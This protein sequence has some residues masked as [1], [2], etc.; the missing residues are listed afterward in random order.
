MRD[1][2]VQLRRVM[3]SRWDWRQRYF[4]RRLFTRFPENIREL[5]FAFAFFVY[6]LP[7]LWKLF[8][9]IFALEFKLIPPE[10]HTLFPLF[11]LS[12]QKSNSPLWIGSV[13][14]IDPWI[15]RE[16]WLMT[17]EDI[18]NLC[19]DVSLCV[20]RKTL[21]PEG[22]N[23]LF[24]LSSWN[25]SWI[26]S[27]YEKNSE[28]AV[29]LT[30]GFDFSQSLS[31]LPLASFFLPV[32]IPPSHT[33]YSA[34]LSLFKMM[35]M[36]LY[37]RCVRMIDSRDSHILP[38]SMYVFRLIRRPSRLWLGPDCVTSRHLLL[39]SVP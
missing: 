23:T 39:T 10:S 20:K 11:S 6:Q 21:L 1:G 29:R 5:D 35:I 31:S 16:W 22:R 14:P 2:C 7:F 33:K 9:F 28:R 4:T 15:A 27:F 34:L 12:P 18:G 13:M 24:L 36:I 38:I 25:C 19:C 26:S 37:I 30:N 32:F 3:R 17:W 8:F